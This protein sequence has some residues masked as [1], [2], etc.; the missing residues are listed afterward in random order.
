MRELIS[1]LLI[2][3]CVHPDRR[4][5][6]CDIIRRLAAGVPVDQDEISLNLS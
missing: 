2:A 3:A 4:D 1:Q 5:Q 6:I